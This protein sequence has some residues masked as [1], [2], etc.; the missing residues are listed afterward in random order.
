MS[1]RTRTRWPGALSFVVSL[2][3]T[4]VAIGGS[5][6]ALATPSWASLLP[7]AWVSAG[8]ASA[9]AALGAAWLVTCSGALS[10]DL[11]HLCLE[12]GYL[13]LKSFLGRIRGRACP[14]ESH[15]SGRRILCVGAVPGFLTCS[16]LHCSIQSEWLGIVH[17]FPE[18][19][20]AK[21]M[22]ESFYGHNFGCLG[23]KFRVR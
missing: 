9:S 18:R 1:V 2:Y 5:A 14:T 7:V 10:P 19:S 11:F 22:Y 20:G 21:R 6:R 12:G 15:F 23:R 13:C 17:C 16:R 8:E 3:T 4:V